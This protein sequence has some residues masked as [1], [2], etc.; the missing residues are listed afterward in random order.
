VAAEVANYA[1]AFLL[2]VV[3][4]V[5][6]ALVLGYR[7]RAEIAAVFWV[8]VFSHPLV[9]YLVG[10]AGLLRAASLSSN[11]VLVLEAGVVIVEWLLLCFALP[12]RSMAHLLFLSLA[13]NAVS[14]YFPSLYQP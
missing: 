4:E 2:T 13:M 14:Y 5:G 12:C 7:R 3:L 11:E 10:I 6:V 9:N 8:N 1:I